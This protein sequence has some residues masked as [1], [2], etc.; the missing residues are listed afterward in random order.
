MGQF[1]LDPHTDFASTWLYP[2]AIHHCI[3]N[4]GSSALKHSELL[5]SHY[6]DLKS[7]GHLY[8]YPFGVTL[9]S[10]VLQSWSRSVKCTSTFHL[11]T[12]PVSPYY[13]VMRTTNAYG[14]QRPILGITI[15]L[16]IAYHLITNQ[17]KDYAINPLLSIKE[18]LRTSSQ[19]RSSLE[20]VI[21]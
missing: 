8:P 10:R 5:A 18:V 9:D 4:L 19:H 17:F 20:D 12:I 1:H 21:L 14:K 11:H 13:L 6:G 2:V 7:K 15:I 3:K 16:V